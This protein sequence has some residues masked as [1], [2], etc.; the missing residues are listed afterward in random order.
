MSKTTIKRWGIGV[1]VQRFHYRDD[2]NNVGFK[3]AFAPITIGYRR[4][5][6]VFSIRKS[7]KG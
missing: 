5:K 3:S 1:Q 4:G 2:K 7:K 6:F